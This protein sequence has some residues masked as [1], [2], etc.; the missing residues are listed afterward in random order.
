MLVTGAMLTIF[1]IPKAFQGKIAL[2]QRNAITSWTKLNPRPQIML[3]GDEIGTAEIAKELNIQHIRDI[4]C[5]QQGTPLVSAAFSL[6]HKLA[7]GDVLTYINSDIILLS[8]FIAALDK[9]SWNRFMM[10][11]QRWNLSLEGTLEFSDSNWESKLRNLATTSGN[12]EGVQAMDYFVFPF[13][14]YQ[15]I[16]P[17]AVGRPGWDNWMLYQAL[18]LGL[19]VIDATPAITA[20]HQ[21]H[22]Y[23]HHPQGKKGAYQGEEAK[24]NKEIIGGEDYTYFRLDLASWLMTSQGVQLAHWNQE[25][26][27]RC[28]EMLPFV[29]P[30]FRG[31]ATFLSYLIQQDFYSNLDSEIINEVYYSLGRELFASNNQQWFSF[32]FDKKV[33]QKHLSLPVPTER[34]AIEKLEFRMIKKDVEI[35]K[36]KAKQQEHKQKI[37][38]LKEAL[39]TANSEAKHVKKKN[40]Q[41]RNQMDEIKQSKFWQLRSIWLQIKHKIFLH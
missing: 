40:E 24:R 10:S 8:D 33:D 7:Q 29:Q 32:S 16:P 23:N 28:L 19:P 3:F 14:F 1:A 5:N 2:I 31:S 30:E 38:E 21:N 9:L 37:S 26:L 20:I 12:L 11:G 18:K 27:C 25:K 35:E 22:D 39:K 15:N 4:E 6:A 36:L 41:L 13:G 34:R 17:F